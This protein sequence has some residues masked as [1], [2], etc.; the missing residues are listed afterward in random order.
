L[1]RIGRLA[2]GRQGSTLRAAEPTFSSKP[3]P[4]VAALNLSGMRMVVSALTGQIGWR[5]FI[6]GLTALLP[7]SYYLIVSNCSQLPVY[8]ISAVF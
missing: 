2:R 6:A 7:L 1:A 4:F 3:V 5:R 8:I